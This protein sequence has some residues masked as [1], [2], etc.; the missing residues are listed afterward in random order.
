MFTWKGD[1]QLLKYSLNSF[2]KV[3]PQARIILFDQAG[4]SIATKILRALDPDGYH[5]TD[6]PRRGNLIGQEWIQHQAA[7]FGK[8][9]KSG[10]VVKMDPDYFHLS[11]AW[12]D[13]NAHLSGY[14]THYE[15]TALGHCYALNQEGAERVHRR[16]NSPGWWEWDRITEDL[17]ISKAVTYYPDHKLH[18]VDRN[19]FLAVSDMGE[20]P[21]TIGPYGINFYG[22]KEDMKV[23]MEKATHEYFPGSL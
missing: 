8:L 15:N 13:P 7:I 10:S 14:A 1:E 19:A 21:A 16:I 23:K 9:A 4:A 17:E 6:V 20:E 18:L 3:F 2:R 12:Y 5:E 22:T 11:D